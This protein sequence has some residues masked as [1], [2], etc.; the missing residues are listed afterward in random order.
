MAKTVA[1]ETGAALNRR[2]QILL[3]I[4]NNHPTADIPTQMQDHLRAE[5]EV[6]EDQEA[7]IKETSSAAIMM[8]NYRMSKCC[9]LSNPLHKM[10]RIFFMLLLLI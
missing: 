8:G 5:K 2:N 7:S 9:F 1:E 10:Q 6:Q 4:V 3:L